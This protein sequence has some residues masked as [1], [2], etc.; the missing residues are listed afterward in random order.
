[1]SFLSPTAL[2]LLALLGPLLWLWRFQQDRR[3]IV[4]PSLAPFRA[5][6]EQLPKF[7]MVQINWLLLLQILLLI[8]LIGTLAK[9]R[10]HG[11]FAIRPQQTTAII[12]DN[13]ASMRAESSNSV[14][15]L[16]ARGQAVRAA[17][18]LKNG[19][20]MLV[21]STAPPTVMSVQWVTE[22]VAVRRAIQEITPT[23]MGGDLAGAIQLVQSLAGTSGIDQLVV[24]TD[25]LAP[26]TVPEWV[27]WRSVGQPAPNIALT[28]VD[29]APR[30]AVGVPLTLQGTVVNYAPMSQ[31]VTVHVSTQD[32]T[33]A[34]RTVMLEPFA[35][36]TVLIEPLELVTLQPITIAVAAAHNDL[37]ADDT[38]VLSPSDIQTIGI[39]IDVD[40]E[41]SR[42]LTR[43]VTSADGFILS[44]LAQREI[45]QLRIVQTAPDAIPSLPTLYVH[46]ASRRGLRRVRIVDW[47]AE[48]PVTRYLASADQLQ[49]QMY[50]DTVWPVWAQPVLW[51]SDGQ[52]S[53][54]LVGV[55]V[56]NG[57]REVVTRLAWDRLNF[58]DARSVELIILLLNM[59]QWLVPTNAS[60]HIGTGESFTA[61][62]VAEGRVH[63]VMPGKHTRTLMHPGGPWSFAETYWAGQYQ[64]ATAADQRTFHAYLRDAH[65]SNLQ[66]M[67]ARV[68]RGIWRAGTREGELPPVVPRPVHRNLLWIAAALFAIEWLL[69]QRRVRIRSA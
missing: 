25:R 6:R 58:E 46:P 31:R 59:C 33:L 24:V 56:R 22:T 41:M 67:S 13:S 40:A 49:L 9:P 8:A 65:E 14:A 34:R 51:G 43:L 64:I 45:P 37:S 63:V 23:D 66:Q 18:A 2:W 60:I 16:R 48:H 27:H 55:G 5:L 1:M 15:F 61:P 52:T 39:H 38:V 30:L 42:I 50:T 11:L 19:D 20:R 7:H 35:R 54:P 62:S 53:W 57:M 32:A 26:E 10:L 69:Y 21:V 68:P 28:F 29:V 3:T 44:A 47:D 36:A 17:K 12:L 4:V